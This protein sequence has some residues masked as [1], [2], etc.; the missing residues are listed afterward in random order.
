[1]NGNKWTHLNML[2]LQERLRIFC[3]AADADSFRDAATRLGMSPQVVTR[4]VQELEA[5]YG[6]LLF[7]RTTR[8]VRITEFGAD[9]VPR[10]RTC[11]DQLDALLVPP[12]PQAATGLVG[13]VRVTAPRSLGRLR[14][15]P[16]LNQIANQHPGIVID[17]RLSDELT[18]VVDGQIDI[19]VRMGLFQDNQFVVRKVGSVGFG[20]YAS[21]ALVQRHGEPLQVKDLAALP[22][23]GLID[24]STGRPWHWFFSRD[25]RVLPE[26]F[27]FITNDPEAECD[28]VLSG[29]AFGQLPDYLAI[30]YV[31]SK[32]LVSVLNAD[33][34]APWDVY[35]YRPQRG[36][37]PARVRLVFDAI[38][39]ALKSVTSSG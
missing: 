37:V 14:V 7:H 38:A 8:R 36:P 17:L 34:P 12:S 20:V 16:V 27:A 3:V 15:L 31:E 24:H 33:A 4:A 2:H 25:R 21:P 5:H 19:G 11:L 22:T 28:A 10:V 23:T 26:P 39:D 6:E 32:R 13:R 18:D 29:V 1:M 35:V 9:L 30:Q